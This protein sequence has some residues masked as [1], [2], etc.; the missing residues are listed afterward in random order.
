MA[1]TPRLFVVALVLAGVVAA[2]CSSTDDIA[3]E[4]TSGGTDETSESV[5]SA[6]TSAAT[7]QA[8]ATTE[9]SGSTVPP[10][11]AAG[12]SAESSLEWGACDEATQRKG[13]EECATLAVPLD[14]DDPDGEQIEIAVARLD[15][16]SGDDQ[17]GSLVFNPGGP[18][19]SGV[20]YLAQAALTIPSDV[21]QRFDLV[22][23]DP[24]GV[25]ASSAVD[26]DVPI[27][28]N[29]N[30]LSAGDDAGWA[31]LVADADGF[32]ATCDAASQDLFKWVGTNNAARDLDRLREALGDDKLSYVGYSYGTR[33]GATYAELFPDRIRALVLDGAVKPSTDLTDLSLQQAT[34]FDRALDNFAAACDADDDCLLRE[35]G[36]TLEVIDTLE[37][38]IAEVGS[39]E[40]DD[41]G[42]VLTPGEL[43]MGVFAALYSQ[44]A[45]P[46]L[47]Q[48]LYVAEVSQDGS[49]LQALADSYNGRRPDG[50]YDNSNDAN[51]AINCADDAERRTI[52][53]ER[54]AGEEAA[55]RSNYFADFLR[56][57]TGCYPFEPSIDPLVLG[58][59]TGAPPILVIGT[60]GDP[61][62]PYEWAVELADYLDSGV[63]YTVEGEGHTAYGSIGCVA[64]AVNAYLIDLEVPEGDAS[65]AAAPSDDLFQPV[66][67]SEFEQI[68]AYLT[69]LSENGL[70]IPEIGVDELIADPFGETFSD[71]ID[72]SDPA[73]VTA[74]TAC[75]EVAPSL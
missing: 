7:T 41:P 69:C 27:D 71:A 72:P 28:D 73:F 58:P 5:E 23:F 38:E 20:D 62:T 10:T 37:A 44:E 65:C 52:D 8:P 53:D 1:R 54:A 57:G 19:G 2:G 33:L 56:A 22:G 45:W 66:G 48:G 17:I 60:T 25:G 30:L 4:P 29:I 74:A 15:T 47:V 55:A 46:I 70:D 13:I 75:A 61:A 6:Q 67:E 50:T 51:I 18:G 63:L 26:C 11:T 64:D 68:A 35:L 9:S 14:Y 49:I 40:T 43:T 24:R 16:A 3:T 31:E 34:G 39:F 32:L 36:P 21:Q 59:A 42:R 12:G